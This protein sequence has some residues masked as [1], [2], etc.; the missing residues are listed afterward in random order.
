[1]E[2]KVKLT[3]CDECHCVL[4]TTKIYVAKGKKMCYRCLHG[5]KNVRYEDSFGDNVHIDGKNITPRDRETIKDFISM[6]KENNV[7]VKAKRGE[8]SCSVE[9]LSKDRVYRI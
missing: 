8:F 4:P 2:D 7:K 1:M 3:S 6:I 9:P 5:I